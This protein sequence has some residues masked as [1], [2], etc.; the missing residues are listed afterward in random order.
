MFGPVAT[1]RRLQL[2]LPA[3]KTMATPL[4][5]LTLVRR[6]HVLVEVQF[7][8]RRPAL[9]PAKVG[10]AVEDG[11]DEF[12]AQL[13]EYFAGSR[14]RFDLP[15]AAMGAPEHQK[16]WGLVRDIPYG[17]TTTYGRL[18]GELADGTNAQEVGAAVAQ[19]PLCIVVPCHRVVG[20]DGALTGYAGGL[21]R[22]RFLLDLE[23]R[24]AGHPGRLF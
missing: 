5:T 7:P 16:I 9:E 6:G 8:G 11:F 4:G 21:G 14:R 3:H 22:K 10:A 15:H 17:E 12:E 18:A 20:A 1:G 2:E 13:D 24:V 19:N 23:R